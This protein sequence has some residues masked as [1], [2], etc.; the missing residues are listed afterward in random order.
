M[1]GQGPS[2]FTGMGDSSDILLRLT[3]ARERAEAQVA[4]L[5][6][7]YDDLVEANALAGTTDDEHDPEGSSTAFERAHVAALLGSARTHVAEFD[8]ALA[9]LESGE[10]GRCESCGAPIPAERL[11]V[12]PAAST[13]V[14]CAGK[15]RSRAR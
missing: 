1:P 11:E 8:E 9:R 12:R 3:A 10:Y 15:G 4:A 13:C 5:S 2:F 14:K 6:R 7:E